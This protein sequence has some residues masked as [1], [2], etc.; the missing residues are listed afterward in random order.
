[1]KLEVVEN[2]S[3]KLI[4][5]GVSV[6]AKKWSDG[7]WSVIENGNEW[8]EDINNIKLIQKNN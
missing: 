8:G 1:M 3:A 4:P 7:H 6:I 5:T 2:W